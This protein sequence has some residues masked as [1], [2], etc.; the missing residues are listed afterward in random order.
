MSKTESATD[1]N[2]EIAETEAVK[3]KAVKIKEAKPEEVKLEHARFAAKT[4]P[5]EKTIQQGKTQAYKVA[6]ISSSHHALAS[7]H[8]SGTLA[9]VRVSVKD[10]FDVKGFKTG[11]GLTVWRDSAA[12]AQKHAGAVTRL[13]QQGAQ[14][15]HKTQLDQLAYSLAGDNAQYGVSRNPLAPTRASGGS[16]SGAAV[17]LVNQACDLALATDTGGSIRVPSS[18]C[19]LYGLRP[20]HGRVPVDGLIPLAPRFDT[21]GLMSQRLSVLEQGT[22]V[23][24]GENRPLDT[25]ASLFAEQTLL[26]CEAL[27]DGVDCELKTEAYRRYCEFDGPKRQIASP[28]LNTTERQ[29]CFA[30]LQAEAIWQTHGV[31]L[32]DHLTHFG[33]DIAQRLRWGQ[34]LTTTEDGAIELIKANRLYQ[35]WSEQKCNWLPLDSILILPTVPSIAPLI[36][37][38][39]PIGTESHST[40]YRNT[41]LGLTSIAGLSGWPQLQCPVHV[42]SAKQTGTANSSENG[43]HGLPHGLSLLGR[44]GSDMS[45]F[46]MAKSVFSTLDIDELNS[47]LPQASSPVQC[48]TPQP[49]TPHIKEGA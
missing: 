42:Q 3:T 24:L 22:S 9:H 1:A 37:S 4:T 25:A 44:E 23:L 39:E 29:S 11:A 35:R 28:P 7:H 33:A 38:P 34:W 32:S 14:L 41:L 17:S 20:T 5:C 36:C 16:S 30:A 43:V 21:A 26:W 12:P 2:T 27:W 31:W 47:V 8:T 19:G 48:E 6:D 10:L 15:V 13:V 45:L 46:A 18:Y 49:K 40:D